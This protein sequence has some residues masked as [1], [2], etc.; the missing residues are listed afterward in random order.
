MD[1]DKVLNLTKAFDYQIRTSLQCTAYF[2]QKGNYFT[3]TQYFTNSLIYANLF[4]FTT[5]GMVTN[6][7]RVSSSFLVTLHIL[8]QLANQCWNISMLIYS[9]LLFGYFCG[10][11]NRR[12]KGSFMLHI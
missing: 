7:S 6:G 8:N 10:D 12:F 9:D 3:Q 2:V 1:L 4:K 5:S 11:D